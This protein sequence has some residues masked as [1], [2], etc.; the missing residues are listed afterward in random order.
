MDIFQPNILLYL[1]ISLSGII[2]IYVVGRLLLAIFPEWEGRD[3]YSNV[4]NSYMLGTL[5][6]ISLFAIIWSRGNSIFLLYALL[7]LL[8][9]WWRKN[10]NKSNNVLNYRKEW[11]LLGISIVLFSVLYG[12]F[13]YLFFVRSNGAIFTDLLY[14]ADSSHEIYKYHHESLLRNTI[15]I[16]EPYHW[17]EHWLN[18]LVANIWGK[19]YLYTLM[20][21]TYPFYML[22][23]IWGFATIAA[24]NEK[25]PLSICLLVGVLGIF[26]WNLSSLLTPWHGS[27]LFNSPKNFIMISCILWGIT[28]I[29]RNRISQAAVALLVTC[30]MYSTLI[31][32]ILTLVVLLSWMYYYEMHV[33]WKEILFNKYAIGAVFVAVCILLFYFLQPSVIEKEMILKHGN[34][35]IIDALAF[36]TKRI[37]RPIASLAPLSLLLYFIYYRKRKEEWYRYLLLVFG[38]LISS[39]VAI[40]M[41]GVVRQIEIDGGQIATNYYEQICFLFCYTGLIYLFTWCYDKYGKM[42]IVVLPMVLAF[43]I[44]YAVYKID[45]NINLVSELRKANEIETYSEI[46]AYF[47]ENPVSSVGYIRNYDIP[48]NKN[49]HK[50]RH[51]LFYPMTKLTHIM[52]Q[53]YYRPYCLSVFDLPEDLDPLWNDSQASDLYQYAIHQEE[54]MSQEQVLLNFIQDK[55]I[56]YIVVEKDATLPEF[57]ESHSTLVAECNGDR[58]V[59]IEK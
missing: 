30:S 46:M 53:G 9:I 52:P 33:S 29:Q 27:S 47:Q 15:S 5:S 43:Y 22:L 14:Y 12:L 11:I 40:F 34:A 39:I 32:G 38:V 24:A 26:Y 25:L 2:G 42:L 8:Y 10:D 51:D 21:F 54:G 44:G 17:G 56:N 4:F 48:E 13:Y 58:L 19:N 18:A 20:L 16:A 3:E 55:Q 7:I 35:Y 41:G 50:S 31:P 23:C 36:V 49:T 59:Y 1:L 45:E 57:L 37:A 6:V 28:L